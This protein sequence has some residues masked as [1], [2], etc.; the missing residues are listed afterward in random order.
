M[1][2]IYSQGTICTDGY[3]L[4]IFPVLQEISLRQRTI[5]VILLL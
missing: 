2:K 4:F 3:F 5:A 1:K